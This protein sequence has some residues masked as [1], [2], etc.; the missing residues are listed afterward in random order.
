[1]ILYKFQVNRDIKNS[2]IISRLSG[3]RYITFAVNNKIHS[4]LWDGMFNEIDLQI[5]QFKFGV[6]NDNL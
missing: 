2:G 4:V 5:R 3:R 1:M 6:R